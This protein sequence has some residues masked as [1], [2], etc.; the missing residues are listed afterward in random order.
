MAFLCLGVG[1]VVFD[2]FRCWL[3]GMSLL[4]LCSSEDGLGVLRY[5]FVFDWCGGLIL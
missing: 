4:L 3:F 1:F 5:F 2:L